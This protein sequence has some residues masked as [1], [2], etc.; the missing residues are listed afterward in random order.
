MDLEDW[1]YIEN[2]DANKDY[3]IHYKN[4]LNKA[5]RMEENIIDE[6]PFAFLHQ[7]PNNK[8]MKIM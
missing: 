1:D 5:I 2:D 3:G 6:I 7:E 4:S 8:K